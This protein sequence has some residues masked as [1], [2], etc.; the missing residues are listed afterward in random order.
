PLVD[1]V[2]AVDTKRWRRSLL[3]RETRHQIWQIR[4]EIRDSKYEMAIDFQGSIK[5]AAIARLS[6]ATTVVGME[7]PR[8]FPAKFFYQQRVSN[9]AVHVI[10]Q[11]LSLAEAV[12]GKS[13]GRP[14]VE[15][16]KDENAE[17][18]IAKKLSGLS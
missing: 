18:N 7:H 14:A 16:P 8:E 6:G 4:R 15:F 17:A 13:L 11:Y 12:V 10:E 1:A 3:S 2:H 5:S 9:S